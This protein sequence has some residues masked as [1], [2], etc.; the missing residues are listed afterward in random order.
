MIEQ[1]SKEIKEV[2]NS[3]SSEDKII[4]NG[5]TIELNNGFKGRKL[6][7]LLMEGRQRLFLPETFV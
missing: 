3:F 2:L 4:F 1:I 5:R 6:L 7:L